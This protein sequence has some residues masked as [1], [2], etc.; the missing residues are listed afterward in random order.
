MQLFILTMRSRRTPREGGYALLMVIFFGALLLIAATAIGPQILTEGR[1]QMEKEM[2]WRG[3]QYARAIT[4]YQR[5]TGRF[6]TS[7]DD[8]VKGQP[9]V[10]F[11]RKQYKDPFNQEDGSWRLIYIGPAGQLVGSLAT[12]WP[13]G[14]VPASAGPMSS[15]AP[16][17]ASTQTAGQ[18]STGSAQGTSTTSVWNPTQSAPPDDPRGGDSP[19]LIGGQIVGVGSKV[20]RKSIMTYHGARNYKHFE[21]VWDPLQGLALLKPAGPDTTHALPPGQPSPGEPP[22]PPQTPGNLFQ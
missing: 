20:N 22:A 21:F 18:F 14:Q 8:L 5:K 15:A 9:G 4:L 7:L 12:S 1:R 3:R 11:L 17:V 13:N 6:P 19:T 16:A 2:I 10:R